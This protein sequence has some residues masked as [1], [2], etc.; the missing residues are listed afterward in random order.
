MD[1]HL[2]NPAGRLYR[3]FEGVRGGNG[4]LLRQVASYY[5]VPNGYEPDLFSAVSQT[6][7]LVNETKETAGALINPPIPVAELL[8]AM[9]K[10]EAAILALKNLDANAADFN[11][12]LDETTL[13]SL[14]FLSHIINSSNP[15]PA[16]TDDS[17][18]SIREAAEELLALIAGDNKLEAA[19]RRALYEHAS[20]ILRALDLYKISGP[21]VV[22]AEWDRLEGHLRHNPVS[23]SSI[24]ALPKFQ[25]A[26]VK[27]GTALVLF[28]GMVSSA[29][30]IESGIDKLLELSAPA[31]SVQAPVP[32]DTIVPSVD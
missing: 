28:A 21:V 32:Q 27:L 30:A 7:K 18:A 20:A 26:V 3:F 2:R 13:K 11:R 8:E 22:L 29:V 24:A 31:T 16:V 1:E 14:K 5:G 12:Q 9:P 10:A 6:W 19:V 15:L 4:T 25:K 23:A 17:L